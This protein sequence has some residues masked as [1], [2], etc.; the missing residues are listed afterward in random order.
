[1]NP[2]EVLFT[3]YHRTILGLLLLRPGERFHV[4]ELARIT[5]FQAGTLN[6]QLKRLK[7]GGILRAEKIGNQVFYSADQASP[8]F[9]DLASLFRKT[10]GLV[11]VVQ[12][13]LSSKWE[14]IDLALIFGSVAKGTAKSQ[15][16]LD[17]LVVT[18]LGLRE[19]VGLLS[20]LSAT[21][22]REINPVVM[23]AGKFASGLKRKDRLLERINE[24]PKL[25]VKGAQDEFAKLGK[26]GAT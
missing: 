16:D 19:I 4:R 18:G 1:M 7:E 23:S 24:E 13:A 17:I 10:S 12:D 6:R 9:E 3:G 25:F 2:D 21:L 14:E 11:Y 20:P 22:N 5:G 8:V 15:S 26:T